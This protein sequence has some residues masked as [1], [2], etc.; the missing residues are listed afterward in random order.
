[1]LLLFAT[2]NAHPPHLIAS[3][4]PSY[5][6]FQTHCQLFVCQIDEL[7]KQKEYASALALLKTSPISRPGKYIRLMACAFK[8]RDMQSLSHSIYEVRSSHEEQRL[9]WVIEWA[10]YF[11]VISCLYIGENIPV[12]ELENLFN[13][14]F[15]SI[16]KFFIAR[17]GLVYGAPE[18]QRYFR[19]NSIFLE[20]HFDPI[21]PLNFLEPLVEDLRPQE[22]SLS[23]TYSEMSETALE[24]LLVLIQNDP[25]KED[26]PLHPAS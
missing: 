2:Q 26:A 1:M 24:N 21:I 10:N 17:T 6:A 16:V 7:I 22:N 14:S 12:G 20:T 15:S 4:P 9:S 19:S 25:L 3:F 5:S 11:D 23:S 13:N 8:L 18:T